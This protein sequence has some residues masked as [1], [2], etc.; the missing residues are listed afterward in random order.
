MTEYGFLRIAAA[1]PAIKVADCEYNADNIIEMISKAESWGTKIITFPELSVTSYSCGDL[2]FQDTLIKHGLL[3]LERIVN[4]TASW[5]IISIIGM[6]IY[7]DNRL[8][9]CAIVING[10]KILGI[11]PKIF[12]RDFGG[13]TEG[14][15]FTSGAVASSSY[16]R[17]LNREIPFGP[18]IL[19]HCIKDPRVCFGIEISSDLWAAIPPSSFHGISG[20]HMVFN[21]SSAFKEVGS[22]E[23]VKD[24]VRIQSKKSNVAYIY[25]SSGINES[26][27]DGV[28]SGYG[29][30]AENGIILSETQNFLTQNNFICNDIDI[31]IIAKEKTNNNNLAK[32]NN[33]LFI[34]RNI[35][36]IGNENKYRKICFTLK[37]TQQKESKSDSEISEKLLRKV[38]PYPFIPG[39]GCNNHDKCKE[40]FEI[41]TAGLIKRIL[42]TKSVHGV[43]GISG[44]LDSTLALLVLVNSFNKIEKS[45]ENIIG[46]TM[47]GFGTSK[48]TYENA[49][50]LAQKLNISIREI[51]IKPA[52]LQHFKD[53]GHE[54]AVHDITYENVQARERYQIL[55]DIA[56]K[57]GGLVIGAA[58]LSELALGWCTYNGD[59]MSMYNVNCG[60]PKTLVKYLISW[61]AGNIK[62]KETRDILQRI[63]NTP[64]S[65]ELLP[66]TS[67]GE[68]DQRT[69]DIVGPYELH[70]FFLY[71][72]IKWGTNPKKILYLA[73]YAF[74]GKYSSD[75]IK[76]WLEVFL[77]RFFTQQFKRSCMPDGP[78]ISSISL[79]PRGGYSMPSDAEGTLWLKE[80]SE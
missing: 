79:S 55:M 21:L 1:I 35:F 57:E 5:D 37:Q 30:I 65:P 20:A 40:I 14:R 75:V 76:K 77:R 46:V 70:D 3:Q 18:N 2:F 68:I 10:G 22:D 54:P 25:A 74:E 34:D 24:L 44:G 41:Q 31:E 61:V 15:W 16:I 73:E 39:D 48:R 50:R 8:F 12:I 7:A 64:I 26:T 38:E 71:H 6:P 78:R 17:L 32:N 47:P 56:N 67:E 51:D 11:V 36:L 27:T 28:F 60:V 53:I 52:C 43:I 80:I 42:H 45:K 72:M 13:Y 4:I 33:Q 62:D 58:D 9:D 66:L 29:I 63:A 59:H 23:S 19:F 69:E 49:I